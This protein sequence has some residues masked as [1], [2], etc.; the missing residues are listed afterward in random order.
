MN[1]IGIP[2]KPDGTLSYHDYFCIHDDLFD[3]IQST[4]KDRTILWKFISNEPNEINL[5]V[6]QQRYTMTKSKIRRGVLPKNQ[7]RI[8]FTEKG[9]KQLTMGTNNL[10]NSG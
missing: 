5:K 2:E 9:K 3:R 6:K 10:M 8:L 1:L 7:P 4:Y